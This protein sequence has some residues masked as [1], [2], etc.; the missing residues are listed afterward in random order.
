M[1]EGGIIDCM[2]CDLKKA[3]N[4]VPHRRLINEVKSYGIQGEILGYLVG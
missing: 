4:K 3:F 1:D 2:Y